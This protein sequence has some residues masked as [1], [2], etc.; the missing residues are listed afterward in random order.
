MDG[1]GVI[2]Y[3]TKADTRYASKPTDIRDQAKLPV[4]LAIDVVINKLT[5]ITNK[6]TNPKD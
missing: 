5:T 4:L 6:Q 2:R 3:R 1:R